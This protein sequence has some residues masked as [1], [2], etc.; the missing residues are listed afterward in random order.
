[1]TIR[2]LMEASLYANKAK[3]VAL[4]VKLKIAGDKDGYAPLKQIIAEEQVMLYKDELSKTNTDERTQEIRE[5]FSELDNIRSSV[6][7]G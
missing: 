5:V 6:L 2:E 3:A 4:D 7:N 1:M